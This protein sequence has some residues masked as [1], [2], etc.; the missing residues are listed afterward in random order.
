MDFSSH[1][2]K[3]G[4]LFA[5]SARDGHTRGEFI[6]TPGSEG[7]DRRV[8]WRLFDRYGRGILLTAEELKNLCSLMNNYKSKE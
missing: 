7:A 3:D 6:A 8:A 4:E 1:V 2:P 5:L